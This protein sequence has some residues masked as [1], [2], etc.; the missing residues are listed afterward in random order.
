[1]TW[2]GIIY[3]VSWDEQHPRVLYEIYCGY[4]VIRHRMTK[5]EIRQAGYRIPA[6][7]GE[8]VHTKIYNKKVGI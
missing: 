8:I 6:I 7:K 3:I 2:D 1:M 5:E 4:L